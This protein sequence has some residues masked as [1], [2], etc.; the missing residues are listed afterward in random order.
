MRCCAQHPPTTYCYGSAL[1]TH[2]VLQVRNAPRADMIGVVEL[3]V[4]CLSL[5][6]AKN[7]CSKDGADG[8]TQTL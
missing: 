1:A 7:G 5:S 4:R 2:T 6:E 3:C 8:E